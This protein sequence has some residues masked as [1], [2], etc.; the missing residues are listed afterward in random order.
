MRLLLKHILA[1]AVFAGSAAHAEFLD[2][3]ELGPAI[4]SGFVSHHIDPPHHT[5]YNENN[6]GVG[7]RFGKADVIVGYYHNSHYKGSVYAAYEA[8]W[9]LTENIHAGLLAGGVTGY[10]VAVSPF[11]LPELVLQVKHLELAATYVPNVT[12]NIPSLVAL[13]ARWAW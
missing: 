8:R 12:R 11:V 6:Y 2:R 10:N 13:Q 4:V 3:V 7:Y 9:K 1:A 5:H